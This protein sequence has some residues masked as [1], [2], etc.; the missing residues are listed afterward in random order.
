MILGA[1]SW[2][3][4]LAVFLLAR[5]TYNGRVVGY[6]GALLE[7][8]P[9]NER[10]TIAGV[11]EAMILPVA[12]LS[13]AARILLQYWSFETLFLLAAPFIGAGALVLWRWMA[14]KKP[15]KA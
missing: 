3:G 15:E 9:S 1:L 11:N 12:F 6:Q 4:V 10:G 2:Q 5:A 14:R 13:L 7:L 8:A